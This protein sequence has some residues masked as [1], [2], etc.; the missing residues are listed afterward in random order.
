M[1][2]NEEGRTM[3]SGYVLRVATTAV[4]LAALCGARAY[5]VTSRTLS[6]PVGASAGYELGSAVANAGD[7][8]GDGHADVIVGAPYGNGGTGYAYLYFGG[9]GAD[10]LPDL[11]LT[12]SAT[13]DYFGSA[14]GAAGDVNG[15]GYADVIVGAYGNDNSGVNAGCVY[16]Y[17]GGPGADAVPD[18]VIQG[19]ASGSWF[20]ASVGAAGDQNGDGYSDVIIGAPQAGAGAAYVYF[21]MWSG[22]SLG[23]TLTG[24]AAG[25]QFGG[26]VADAGDVN[27]DGY[28]DL[29]VGAPRNDAGGTDAGR[30][31]VYYGGPLR[32]AIPDVTLTGSASM[33]LFGSPVATAGDI[34]GDGVDE[35]IVCA[36]YKEA[37]YIY[38]GGVPGMDASPDI[39]LLGD[40]SQ[41][42]FACSAGTA[43]DL[44]GDGYDD[45]IVGALAGST[46]G[47]AYVF[48]GGPAANGTPDVVLTGATPGENFGA[49]V[50]G[51]GDVDGD[52]FDDFVVGAPTSDQGGTDAGKAY[53]LTIEHCRVL[54]PNG[55]EQWVAGQP[56][57]VR[58]LGSELVDI[59]I[60]TDGGLSYGTIATGVGGKPQ[61]EWTLLCP[62]TPTCCARI[63]VVYTGQTAD[64][65]TSDASDAT[66]HIV[67]PVHPATVASRLQ[68]TFAGAAPYDYFGW[69]VGT[70]GDVNRDGYAD[71]IVGAPYGGASDAGSA[72]VYFGGPGSDAVA[73]L[74]LT[75]VSASD[76][77]GGSVGTAGDV[78]GDGFS[79]VIVGAQN[80]D[81]SGVDAGAAYV[82]YGGATPNAVPDL[83]LT[84]TLPGD[85]FGK[86]VATAGD[87]NGDGFADVIVGALNANG[88]TGAAY[89]YYG[90]P[91]ADQVPDF[92]FYGAAPSDYFGYSV[93]TAG[94][95][96]GDGYSDVIVGAYGSSAG[97]SQGGCAYVYYGGPAMDNIADLV[98]PGL[99]VGENAGVSV[100]T[101]GDVN[102]D[103]YADVIVGAYGYN[104]T[105][106]R[107]YVYFGGPGADAVPDLTLNGEASPDLFGY[108]VGTAG[109]VNGDGF[110]EVI[111]G[112]LGSDAGG[113]DAG[114]AYVY[115]GGPG[116]DTA[117]DLVMTGSPGAVFGMCVGTA[118]D[119]NGDGF[120][121]VI[122]SAPYSTS[123]TGQA[124]LY[125]HNRYHLVAP[126]GGETWNVGAT[127]TISWLGPEKANV[128]LSTDGGNSY[129]MLKAGVGGS[130]TNAV[131]LQVPHM[132]T[133]FAKIKIA[134]AD[135]LLSG[136]DASDS[137][138]TIQTSVS[139]LALMAAPLPDAPKGAAIS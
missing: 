90:G 138:F 96:N 69:S 18:V 34:N 118:G 47:R 2:S 51:G 103:R 120:A 88:S 44:N 42:R 17:Y 114:R 115:F 31:Y 36:F 132:P 104:E 52:G 70:A 56:S 87:V 110:A 112:A 136:S 48:Y 37:A 71:V 86:T 35:V 4:V 46:N 61:N 107:A 105:T 57:T 85:G 16:I 131:P 79:D 55:G 1:R 63:R 9:P 123:Y 3:R 83:I 91:G 128:W 133:K 93:G 102:G 73:D 137:L 125:D 64:R 38:F 134:P 72:Y 23:L 8:N 10:D 77:F 129:Q 19:P 27:G 111:V 6:A 122:V 13:G 109:D 81:A 59:Q 54:S 67:E 68:R 124:F 14:V 12:G 28:H 74:T 65:S 7:V 41:D 80:N 43:G 106:G 92:V 39:S 11:T 130:T 49:S 126:L 99:T 5:A 84:G 15:D 60:S 33:D 89:L 40:P 24:A 95:V 139:L 62:P 53:V 29:I 101:A 26:S 76:Y 94:D 127:K 113:V 108:S 117:P 30:A 116:T 121:D 82:Y 98:M 20:G 58:W 45:V 97:V 75:G 66:F 22:V 135:A 25:D 119:V 21:G 32:D 50:A 78:N 100:G